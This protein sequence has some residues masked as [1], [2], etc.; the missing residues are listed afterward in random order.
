MGAELVIARSRV[1]PL[2]WVGTL[3]C[4]C[5][6]RQSSRLKNSVARWQEELSTWIFTSPMMTMLV[7]MVQSDVSR[8]WISGRKEECGLGERYMRSSVMEYGGLHLKARHSTEVKSGN[9]RG[10]SFSSAR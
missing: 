4:C 6:P 9:G 3:T 2:V 1:W 8:S 5:R 7:D 10:D